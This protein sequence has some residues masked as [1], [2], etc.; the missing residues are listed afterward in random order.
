MAE[1]LK[2]AICGEAIYLD[3]EGW[4]RHRAPWPL[5]NAQPSPVAKEEKKD[6]FPHASEFY[7]L[8]SVVGGKFKFAGTCF[9]DRDT[10]A[11]FLSNLTYS[12]LG[13][14]EM[15]GM[16]CFSVEFYAHGGEGVLKL[17]AEGA[18]LAE[19]DPTS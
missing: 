13:S 16:K 4:P 11:R 10:A 15:S 5:H 18:T 9:P 2:C 12:K 3:G 6:P 19:K 7:M 17:A 8:G 1:D 14:M